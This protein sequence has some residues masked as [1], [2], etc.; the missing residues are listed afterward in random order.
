MASK[1]HTHN[2]ER[3]VRISLIP[4]V[5]APGRARA[6]RRRDARFRGGTYRELGRLE[7]WGRS[8]TAQLASSAAEASRGLLQQD[9]SLGLPVRL[10]S[11]FAV[12]CGAVPLTNRL[13][14][15]TQ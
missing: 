8:L 6:V 2:R 4:L 3:G 9:P 11:V 5:L 14:R 15:L 13:E 10:R 12:P 7:T 1:I